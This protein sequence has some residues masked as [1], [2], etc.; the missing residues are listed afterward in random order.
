LS[1]EVV[2]AITHRLALEASTIE[3]IVGLGSVNEV[4]LVRADGRDFVVR[5]NPNDAFDL[6]W[7]RY[8]KEAWCLAAARDA[9]VPSP[10]VLGF[11]EALGQAFLVLEYLEGEA[12]ANDLDG[13]RFLGRSA[14]KI[15]SVPPPTGAFAGELFEL[16]QASDAASEWQAQLKLN[17]ESLSGSDPLVALGVYEPA[18][19]PDLLASFNSLKAG[20]PTIGLCHGDLAL[21]NVVVTAG[22]P[23]LLDWGSAALHLVPTYDLAEILLNNQLQRKP[24]KTGIAAF[25]EGY[26]WTAEEM[27]VELSRARV[28][29]RLKSFDLVRWAIDRAPDRVDELAARARRLHRSL[30]R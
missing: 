6:A 13:W 28:F 24:G 15:H 9:G 23:S 14:R 1:T 3:P 10:Q 7:R 5:L 16:W 25:A 19:I 30:T 2:Q 26:G 8:R 20:E 18:E 29:L 17:T 22:G 11:G 21:R 12:P 27:E 4:F